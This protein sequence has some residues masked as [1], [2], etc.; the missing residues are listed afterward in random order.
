MQST[1]K[2]S[3]FVIRTIRLRGKFALYPWQNK[4]DFYQWSLDW[5]LALARAILPHA[6]KQRVLGGPL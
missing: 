5:T 3:R 4:L 6:S 1:K 2:S